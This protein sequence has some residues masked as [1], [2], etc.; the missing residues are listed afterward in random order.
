[1]VLAQV[2]AMAGNTTKPGKWSEER[3]TII[4]GLPGG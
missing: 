3:W 2:L 1:M 4:A